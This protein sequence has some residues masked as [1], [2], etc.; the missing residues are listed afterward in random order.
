M[1]M[2]T[3]GINLGAQVL[4]A[5]P[6]LYFLAR[7]LQGGL[8]SRR[9]ANLALAC[10]LAVLIMPEKLFSLPAAEYPALFVGIGITRVVLG[11]AGLVLA[12]VAISRR[13][14]GGVG[15]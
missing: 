15:S 6:C 7:A 3:W 10:G 13:S 8:P 14:D 4:L 2:A 11:I 12:G 9:S 5:L 1:D